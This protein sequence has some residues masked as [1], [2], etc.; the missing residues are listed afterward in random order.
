MDHIVLQAM[1]K[2]PDVPAC[3]GW[4]GLDAR[5][6]WWMRDDQVQASG[7]FAQA[8]GSLLRHEKLIDFIARNFEADVLGQWFFQNGPQRVYVE[9]EATPI[10]WRVTP[11][12]MPHDP[13]QVISHTGLVA[14]VES[15]WV[16]EQGWVYLLAVR[17]ADVGSGDTRASKRT[18][19]GLVHSQD[20]PV[21]ADALA[22]NF[23]PL[24]EV[25]R[26]DLP[27]RF[28]FVL[29]PATQRQASN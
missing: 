29:S 14:Q 17:V 9:L 12:T 24:H 13:P 22:Q 2:W 26:A 25:L 16:D 11:A 21:V 7:S 3:T 8:K 5:G 19:F 23:W 27:T 20:V 28:A 18:Y 4:L 1:A 15:A 6:Q 10:I